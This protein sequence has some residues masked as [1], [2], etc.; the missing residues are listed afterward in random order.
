MSWE[1]VS[2]FSTTM[3]DA[4]L[5]LVDVLPSL[6]AA[7]VGV[8]LD[9]GRVDDDL[10]RVVDGR[11]DEH[12]GEGRLPLVVGI[13]R[14]EPHEPVHAVFALEVAVSEFAGK[15]Q[16]GRLDAHFVA[17]L[18]VDHPDLVAV[19]FA[20]SRVHP[21][22]HRSPVEAFGTACAGV[23]LHDGAQM[24]LLASIFSSVEA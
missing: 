18:I 16:R 8:P 17:L 5:D 7:A 10:D 1:R 19:G 23:D 22:Q 24:V 11:R 6:A 9:V 13:E 14:R 21:Q 12:R 15:F 2:V 4:G 3:P 20:P